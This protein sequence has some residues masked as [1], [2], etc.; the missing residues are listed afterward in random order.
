MG[1]STLL[2][3]AAVAQRRISGMFATP[4]SF[5]LTQSPLGADL[6]PQAPRSVVPSRHR[7]ELSVA[8]AWWDF[9]RLSPI[10]VPS[11]SSSRNPK[12]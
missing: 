9:R 2:I 7:E 12:L 11:L 6:L 3:I 8:Q 4:V 10:P 5:R 1:L